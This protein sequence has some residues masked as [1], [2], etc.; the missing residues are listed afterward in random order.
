MR[1]PEYDLSVTSA[2]D[3][4]PVAQVVE[5]LWADLGIPPHRVVAPP[6]PVPLPSRLSTADLA[7][8]S[9]HAVRSAAGIDDELDPDRIALSYRSDRHL[10]LDGEAP[11]VWSPYSGFWRTS[12]GWVRTHGNYPHHAE[13][14]LRGLGLGADIDARG[15]AT[16]LE[17]L[18]TSDA[19]DAITREGGLCVA[20]AR[21]DPSVDARL[22]ATPLVAVD[23]IDSPDRLPADP[24]P[25][26]L[27]LAGVRVLDLTRVIAGP[28]CTRTL[29]LLGADVLRIDPPQLAEPDWQHLDTGHGKRSARLDARSERF[30]ALLQSADVVVLGY[31]PS[32]LSRLGLS[33]H[34]LVAR[35][36]GLVVAQLSAW[37]EDRPEL[38]GFDSLVQAASGISW[39]ES[40]DGEVPGAL[41]AQALDHS[42]GYLLAA[43]V[44]EVVNRRRAEGGSWILR[45]SLRRV[46]AELLGMPRHTEPE[47]E[48]AVD[49]ASHVASFDVSGVTLTT[50]RPALPGLE[51]RAPHPWASDQPRW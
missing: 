15:I 2:S 16:T 34:E 50:V 20:V 47:T 38:A 3:P 35:H 32:A 18:S 42:A 45:T 5:R 17:H 9:V 37:G 40:A 39:I 30:D 28:V 26:N 27:P 14:L 7:W 1:A 22:R 44:I 33:P 8:A 25:G 11:E 21:E 49:A 41:P 43:A 10:L 36:P 31:R 46:A 51:F 19:V 24:D 6:H 23:R 48:R 29:A 4:S 12:D 13:R